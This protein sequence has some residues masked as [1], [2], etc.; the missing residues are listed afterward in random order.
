ML[1]QQDLYDLET[2]S[3]S[4]L[5]GTLQPRAFRFLSHIDPSV[6]VSNCY[7]MMHNPLPSFPNPFL[8]EIHPY[9]LSILFSLLSLSLSLSLIAAFAHGSDA[10]WIIAVAVVVPTVL[11]GAAI[12]IAVVAGVAYYKYKQSGHSNVTP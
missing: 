3:P 4:L 12:A 1:D 11:V 9:F 10:S 2:L 7:R 8:P 6:R 5:L